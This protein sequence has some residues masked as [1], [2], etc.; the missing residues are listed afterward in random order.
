MRRMR[1]EQK[2]GQTHWIGEG[3]GT[4][5]TWHNNLFYAIEEEVRCHLIPELASKM[6]HSTQD[7]ITSAVD[8][9]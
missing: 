7:I 4:S 1:E 8:G 2:T 3:Y 5:V 9:Q 6:N